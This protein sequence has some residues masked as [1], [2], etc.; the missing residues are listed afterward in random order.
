MQGEKEHL[1][2][3]DKFSWTTP[4]CWRHQSDRRTFN[5]CVVSACCGLSCF[6][7]RINGKNNKI[8]SFCIVLRA[9]SNFHSIA[10]VSACRERDWRL[11]TTLLCEPLNVI[12]GWVMHKPHN[13]L[14]TS[15]P[16]NNSMLA[17]CSDNHC[18]SD[19]VPAVGSETNNYVTAVTIWRI[20][21]LHIACK[22]FA[23]SSHKVRHCILLSCS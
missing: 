21:V 13:L 5:N 4:E 18:T 15:Q 9:I 2:T 7:R 22:M 10:Q 1:V 3:I 11:R 14:H 8:L 20:G 23:I 6:S 19:P 16:P 12:I 17:T